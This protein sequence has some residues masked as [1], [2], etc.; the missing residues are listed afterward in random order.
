MSDRLTILY[1]CLLAQT[2][3]AA[4]RIEMELAGDPKSSLSHQQWSRTLTQLK[5]AGLTIRAPRAGDAP[6][7]ET[8]V[9]ASQPVYKVTGQ[10]NDRSELIVPGGRF[11]LSNT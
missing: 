8:R 10:I 4:G 5:V 9:T 3:F 6:K 1:F 2:A 7:I 11:S